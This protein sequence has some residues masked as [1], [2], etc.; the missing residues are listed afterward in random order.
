MIA[1]YSGIIKSHDSKLGLQELKENIGEELF[2]L[3]QEYYQK[4]ILQSTRLTQTSY[5]TL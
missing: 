2:S 5:M 3:L 4:Q 1:N